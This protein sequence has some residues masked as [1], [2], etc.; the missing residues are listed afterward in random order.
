MRLSRG[1][2]L[3]LLVLVAVCGASSSA[4]AWTRTV[5]KSARATVDLEGNA[6]LS[7]L[8]RLDVQVHA[9][10]L[11][12]LELVGLGT[13]VELDRSRPPY[14]RSEE[15]QIHRPEVEVHDDGRIQLSFARREA[16]RRGEHRVFMR[17]RTKADVSAVQVGGERRARVVWSVPAWETGLHNVSVEIRAPKGTSVPTEIHDDPPG[18]DFQVA[19]TPEHT[20]VEWRRIH[21]PR[22]TAWPLRL[23][24][25]VESIRLPAAAPDAPEP[26]GFRPLRVPQKRPIAWALLVLAV[27]VL[28][29]RR[30][31]EIRMGRD[32]LLVGLPW[33]AVLMLSGGLLTLGQWLAPNHPV[34]ALPLIAFGLHRPTRWPAHRELRNWRCLPAKDLPKAEARAGDVLDGTTSTGLAAMV[35]STLVLIALGQPSAALLLLPIFLT[36]TRRHMAPDAQQAA[37]SL[38]RFASALRLSSDTPDLAFAWEASSEGMPRLRVY[39]AEHRTGLISV[40]FVVTSSPLGFVLR[41]RVMLLVETRAQSDADDL[42][43]RRTHAEPALRAPEGSILRLLDW[44]TDAVELLRVLGHKPPKPTKASRGS[45]MIREIAER[46]REAA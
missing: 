17:Y 38:R 14:L 28:L 35:T 36:G 20:V 3:L 13:G 10:W 40:S 7:I 30:S 15:G 6:T 22:M 12:E 19:E 45:W 31:V 32:R 39:L 21:L 25:P 16:P 33:A 11:R 26:T 5:V 34:C 42:V 9:G 2:A 44:D 1:P 41:R 4:Q 27:L 24:V 37:E 23:D 29:K 18:V 8:L 43:R 46:A